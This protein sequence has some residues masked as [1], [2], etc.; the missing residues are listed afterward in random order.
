VAVDGSGNLYIADSFNGLIRRVDAAS[1]VI[2]AVA[3]GGTTTGTDGIGDG[4]LATQAQLNDPTGIAVDAAGNLYIA[5]QGHRMIRFV[6]AVSG[7]ITAIAGNGIPGYNGDQGPAAGAEFYSPA[8]VRLDAAGNLY[9]ADSG[10]NAIRQVQAASG[11]INT[12][13]GNGVS[14]YSGDGDLS[15]AANLANPSGLALDSNGNLYIAD[16]GNNVIRKVTFQIRSLS[17]GNTNIGLASPPQLLTVENIGN[18]ALNFSTISVTGAFR[19]QSSGY[20]DCSSSSSVVP[21]SG[22]TIE[23]AFVPTTTFFLTGNVAITTNALN[24]SSSSP[25]ATLSG[26]GSFAPVPKVALSAANLAFGNQTIGTSATLPVTAT[27]AGNAPLGISN[28]WLAGTNSSEFSVTTTCGPVLAIGAS[29]SVSATFTPAAAGARSAALIFYDL[30]ANSPQTVTLTGTGSPAAR[31]TLNSTSL[32]FGG[33][34]IGAAVDVQTVKLTNSGSAVL[35]I[36]SAAITGPNAA[37]FKLTTNCVA[38]LAQGSSCTASVVF[39]PSAPGSRTAFLTFTDNAPDSPQAVTMTGTGV[40]VFLPGKFK[41]DLAVWR[42]SN[43]TW[44]MIPSSTGAWHSVQWGLPGDVAVPGDYDGDG[45]TDIAVWRPSN[46]TWY[47]VPSSTGAW[48]SVQWG[49]P[50]DI[51]VPGDYDG[52]GKTDIAIWRPSNA[53]WYVIPSSTNA[54]YSAQWGL[55]G[56]TPVPGDFDGDGKT[57][58]AVW[59]PS[60]GTWYVIPSSTRAWYSVQ[61]GLL[62]DIPL[63]G[64]FDRDRKSDIAVWRPSNGTWYVVP[65]ST[66]AWYSVQWGLPGDIPVPNDYSGDGETDMA[67]WRPSNGTWYIIPHGNGPWYSQQW[68]LPGDHPQ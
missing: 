37:D 19:Q 20:V 45:K 18:S 5:D 64:D 52:D 57:D 67:V 3:G 1:G 53:T 32:N 39:S 14:G 54:W 58:F 27:N 24:L 44:Y 49:L 12:I 56:D 6:N 43:G 29:C 8:C 62:G 26:T 9:I 47:M 48:Y 68:G 15:T 30:V 36:S 31:A 42:P 17:F 35:S 60:N 41:G 16:N 55:P 63:L 13:A 21:G 66:N 65:S 28:I 11:T 22:C 23:I 38:S 51:A 4:A 25:A 34:N 2:T 50:G 61:W 59:R 7:I 46:G 40:M 10:N 33:Q